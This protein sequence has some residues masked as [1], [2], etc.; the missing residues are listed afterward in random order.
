MH[1]KKNVLNTE[2]YKDID[3]ISRSTDFT[4]I[5]NAISSLFI[6]V[7]FIYVFEFYFHYIYLKTINIVSTV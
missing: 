7:Y 5:P 6:S 3:V 2:W 1:Q 4:K